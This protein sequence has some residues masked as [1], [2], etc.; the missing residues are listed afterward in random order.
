MAREIGDKRGVRVCLT[1]V[2]NF[3][4]IDLGNYR[5]PRSLSNLNLVV[6]TAVVVFAK[7]TSGSLLTLHT[8]ILRS[9]IRGERREISSH[10]I[11]VAFRL[12]IGLVAL[13]QKY[14]IEHTLSEESI[15]IRSDGL[16]NPSLLVFLP[17]LFLQ[18]G[19]CGLR[20]L[21]LL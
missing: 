21:C 19:R 10:A 18:L 15:S 16:L 20:Q 5:F 6:T 2:S 1:S 14:P 17:L 3:L 11:K 13:V 12:R 7:L 9:T 8:L 4:L